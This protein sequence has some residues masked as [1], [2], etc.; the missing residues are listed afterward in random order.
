MQPLRF[1]VPSQLFVLCSDVRSDF[2]RSQ[3]LPLRVATP[4]RNSLFS[5]IAH[6]P[7]LALALAF[8]CAPMSSFG[9]GATP[10]SPSAP[11]PH[12][13]GDKITI[14]IKSSRTL[15]AE[16]WVAPQEYPFGTTAIINQ[17]EQNWDGV[18]LGV[19]F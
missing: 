15:F 9:T 6:A 7:A 1:S 17:L 12:K 8:A 4:P 16:A 5:L 13:A 2:V 19:N 14:E 3:T 10:P 18:C 11:T